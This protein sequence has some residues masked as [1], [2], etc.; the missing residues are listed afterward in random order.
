MSSSSGDESLPNHG[1]LETVDCT[2][3]DD[4]IGRSMTR[5]SSKKQHLA[6]FVSEHQYTYTLSDVRSLSSVARA[7][8]M[9]LWLVIAVSSNSA[10]LR[11]YSLA[12]ALQISKAEFV[13]WLTTCCAEFQ[14]LSRLF[15]SIGSAA[16]A[17]TGL[18]ICKV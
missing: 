9:S 17:T 5:V 14:F 12:H 4:R 7:S 11:S 16:I 15:A 2:I 1:H 13:A 3:L 8:R 6:L 10:F 18:R